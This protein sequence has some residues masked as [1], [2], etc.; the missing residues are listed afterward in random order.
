MDVMRIL[1]LK[2][3]P[4]YTVEAWTVTKCYYH[5]MVIHTAYHYTS[6]IY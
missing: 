4:N 6:F 3:K 1:Y 2:F 5:C